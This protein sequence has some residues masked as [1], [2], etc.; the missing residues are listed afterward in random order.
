[1]YSLRTSITDL[2]DFFVFNCVDVLKGL[3]FF[4]LWTAISYVGIVILG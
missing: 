1:M 2:L 4:E 3:S